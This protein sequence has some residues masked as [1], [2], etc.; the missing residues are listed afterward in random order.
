M[1]RA[2]EGRL[3]VV[4]LATTLP[5]LKDVTVTFETCGFFAA[6]L[7][8]LGLRDAVLRAVG[9]VAV[10]IREKRVD[11]SIIQAKG[12]TTYQML[13]VCHK[14]VQFVNCLQK[15]Q[16][17]RMG[18]KRTVLETVQEF[19]HFIHVLSVCAIEPIR[20]DSFL[21]TLA[22]LVDLTDAVTLLQE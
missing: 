21:V 6:A 22:R 4:T 2:V 5:P 9:A 10:G 18:K 1:R 17:P 8:A 14:K 19:V 13:S 11:S 7:R 16:L 12:L 20:G 3:R 15:I